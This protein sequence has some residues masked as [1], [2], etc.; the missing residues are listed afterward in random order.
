[1]SS[2]FKDYGEAHDAMERDAAVQ[3]TRNLI[4]GYQKSLEKLEAPY[5]QRMAVAETNI[6]QAVLQTQ[7]TTTLF[8]VVAK[9]FK[10]RKSVSWKSVAQVFK[11]SERLVAEFTT[12]GK[13]KVK[14]QIAD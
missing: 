3:S 8:G 10:G 6:I 13:P 2:I 1:M 5:R 4:L 14:V 11:P 7:K 12:V 9:F